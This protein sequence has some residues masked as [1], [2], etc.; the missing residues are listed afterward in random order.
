MKTNIS[1]AVLPVFFLFA[2]SALIAEEQATTN[3]PVPDGELS[4]MELMVSNVT[5]ATDTLW[6]IEDP[7]TDDEWQV[8][9][10]AA[11]ATIEAFEQ[12][13]KGGTGP[14]DNAW[15]ADPVWQ[16]YADEVI[17]A[18]K[19]AKTAISARDMEAVFEAGDALYTPCEAC[20]ID[21]NSAVK[22]E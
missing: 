10:D 7:Q 3:E 5:P 6:G 11:D 17:A 12:A 18:A 1:I 8:F 14:N 9:I 16:A 4:I 15:A 21:F 22:A 2:S 19:S 13:K 20:H